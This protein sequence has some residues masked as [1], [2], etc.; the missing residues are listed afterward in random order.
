MTEKNPYLI[1]P[2]NRNDGDQCDSKYPPV[3]LANAVDQHFQSLLPLHDD[4]NYKSAMLSAAAATPLPPTPPVAATTTKIAKNSA[5]PA[6]PVDTS[7]PTPS[8]T[9]KTP[10]LLTLKDVNLIIQ[11]VSRRNKENEEDLKILAKEC[12]KL[13]ATVKQQAHSSRRPVLGCKRKLLI[14]DIGKESPLFL[15]EEDMN[16]FDEDINIL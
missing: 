7:T 14:E 13:H 16:I 12:R 1:L 9:P 5:T 8:R 15:D 10:T 4:F 11:R 2:C 3:L 6:K